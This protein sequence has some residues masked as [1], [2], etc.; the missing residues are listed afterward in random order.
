MFERLLAKSVKGSGKAETI[1][2]HTLNLLSEYKTLKATY[3]N[4]LTESEWEILRDACYYHDIG[5]ANTKF[6]NKIRDLKERIEDELKE[7]EE[8]PH[9]YLSCAYMPIKK[10]REKYSKNELKCLMMAVYYHHERKE[11][12]QIASEAVI[13]KDLPKYI[14]ALKKE[15]FDL[16]EPPSKN[17]SRY[18]KKP[19]KLQE[20]Y[21]FIRIKGLLNKIDHAASA[22]LP[23]E[24][25][26]EN[27]T[28]YLD[29]FMKNLNSQPN[30]LQTYLKNHPGENLVIVAST[31]IGKTEGALYWIG[32]EKG[33]FTLPLKVSIN[34]IYDRIKNEIGYTNVGL[35]HSDSQLEYMKRFEEEFEFS[36]S[37]LKQTKQLSMPLTVSTIDQVIDF[38]FLYPGFEL[39]LSTLSYCKFVID[40]IQM[41]SPRLVAF[42][43]MGLKYITEMGGK[44][45]IMTATLPPLFIHFLEKEKIPFKRPDK[46][47]LKLNEKGQVIS[48]HVMK[49]QQKDLTAEEA[50]DHGLKRK[51][52]IIVNTVTKAQQ[53]YKEFKEK[54]IKVQ[55][56][57]SRFTKKD[58]FEKETSIKKLGKKT[59]T[60]S[61]IW[62]TTQVVEASIDIDF[63][64]LF[65]EL[66]EATGLFQR[67]G[68]VYRGR[69]YEG[70]E[71]NVYVYT[72]DFLP[73]GISETNKKSVVDYVAFEKSKEVLLQ[74]DGQRISEA[75][76]MEIIEQ[77]YSLENLGEESEYVQELKNTINQLKN[78]LPYEQKEKP[79]LRD[80]ENVQIIPYSVY[81]K[82]EKTIVDLEE[83]LERIKQESPNNLKR[84][85]EIQQQLQ[86]FTVEI[87][88]WAYK[89]ALNSNLF[90]RNVSMGR[91]IHFPV[92]SYKYSAELG[93]IYDIDEDANFM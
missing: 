80:I 54:G 28:N 14:E 27:L 43:I 88:Y 20:L 79:K 6:Q 82:N 84:K 70:Q 32:E 73:S 59:C 46:P 23:V 53:L 21:P 91:F 61:G 16:P 56:L 57:H 40:E 62:I 19:L 45:L 35:L 55:L 58:R 65:T 34:A 1:M 29:K 52:L 87:P 12:N 60:D 90:A 69:E 9:A 86:E 77:I 50:I 38:A 85:L 17:Y 31:G 7:L 93:L 63:D 11:E 18:V 4:I 81:Q 44:F 3:P 49:I 68:R 41:Y 30:E 22:H 25:P 10:L 24:L 39:K 42:I 74:Y 33:I 36:L 26:P 83:E 92:L 72:G 75:L 37:V 5:K 71:P 89:K 64:V 78:L 67:M 48:R 15:G 8:V 76:K 47:F 51:T 13:E 2:E 66:S